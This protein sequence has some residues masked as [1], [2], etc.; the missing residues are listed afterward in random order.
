MSTSTPDLLSL[1]QPEPSR[2]FRNLAPA[3]LTESALRLG[4]ASLT[5]T[6]ALVARTGVFTGRSPKDKFLVDDAQTHTLVDWGPVN[7]PLSPSQ[8]NGLLQRMAAHAHTRDLFV[9]DGFA[10]ADP[11]SRLPLRIITQY[12]WHSL[13]AHQLFVRATPEELQTP[14]AAV[15]H[16]RPAELSG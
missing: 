16:F 1:C 6:G 13:F 10:G 9:F 3:A 11:D 12:A 5:D 4:E 7:Q 14:S 15:Y 2:V 8:F